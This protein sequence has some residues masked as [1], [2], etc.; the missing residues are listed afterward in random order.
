MLNAPARLMAEFVGTFA[1]VL[2]GAGSILSGADLNGTAI[3]HG[4]AIFVFVSAFA[5]ISGGAF[6]PAVTIALWATKRIKSLDALAYIVTQLL[7]GLLAAFVLKFAY[8][9]FAQ[10]VGVPTLAQPIKPIYGLLI[11]VVATFLLMMVIMGVAI[12]SRGTFSAVAGLPSGLI[13]TAGIL[14][15]GPL[16][17]GAMNPARWFGPAIASGQITNFWIWIVGPILGALAAVFLYDGLVKPKK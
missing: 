5:H 13:I 15:A 7:G 16:T 17:G 4:I 2:L 11:E 1:L 8:G 12:D 3:A 9:S 14:F 10:K 6:N